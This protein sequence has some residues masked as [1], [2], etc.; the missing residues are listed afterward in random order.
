MK[1]IQATRSASLATLKNH[2]L[3]KAAA[4]SFIFFFF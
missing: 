3:G 4:L 1:K 2:E